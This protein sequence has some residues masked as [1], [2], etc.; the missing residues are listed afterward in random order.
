MAVEDEVEVESR[1]D[2]I[3]MRSDRMPGNR[4]LNLPMRRTS[5][6]TMRIIINHSMR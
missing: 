2:R 4:P 3:R 1:R 5:A 6:I